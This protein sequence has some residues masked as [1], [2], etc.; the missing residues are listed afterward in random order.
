MAFSLGSLL[1]TASSA[2]AGARR[3]QREQQMQDAEAERQQRMDTFNEYARS[4]QLAQ[5]D[6]AQQNAQERLRD[7]IEAKEIIAARN[8]ELQGK[9]VEINDYKAREAAAAAREKMIRET[10]QDPLNPTQGYKAE[11]RKSRSEMNRE[12]NATAIQAAQIRALNALALAQ[13]RTGAA[14]N[15]PKSATQR[16]ADAQLD[17]GKQGAESA[18]SR[19]REGFTPSTADRLAEAM[20]DWIGNWAMSDD[21]QQLYSDLTKL[22]MAS[23]YAL[24]GKAVTETEAR[25]LARELVIKPGDKPG[26]IESKKQALQKRLD[27]L[28]KNAGE[29]TTDLGLAKKRP[30]NPY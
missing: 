6:N 26:M 27:I 18:A 2:R 28:A 10:G 13:E 1:A 21:S 24:S 19:Y 7:Q 22:V 14:S 8:A 12:D 23:Q 29:E 15:K 11:E 3:G 20:P 17:L 9:N 4:R 30:E 16:Q 25:R 5:T